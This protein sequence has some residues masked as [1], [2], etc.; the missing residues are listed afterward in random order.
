MVESE[1]FALVVVPPDELPLLLLAEPLESAL[2]TAG[3]VLPDSTG[4]G[5]GIILSFCVVSVSIVHLLKNHKDIFI[6]RQ[7]IRNASNPSFLKSHALNDIFCKNHNHS[8]SPRWRCPLHHQ[9]PPANQNLQA[10]NCQPFCFT[11]SPSL[12]AIFSE[13]A[14]SLHLQKQYFCNLDFPELL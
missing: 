13:R 3:A 9:K 6:R 8:W 5:A 12:R 2:E 11:F 4:T 1:V 14:R 7:R 10:A